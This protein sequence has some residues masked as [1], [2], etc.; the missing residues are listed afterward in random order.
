MTV[1]NKKKM[2]PDHATR[3]FKFVLPFQFN[4][5]GHCYFYKMYALKGKDMPSNS[6]TKTCYL[7][8]HGLDLKIDIRYPNKF[9]MFWNFSDD[10]QSFLFRFKQHHITLWFVMCMF[11]WK[12]TIV[13]ITFHEK[14]SFVFTYTHTNVFRLF[15]RRLDPLFSF[16]LSTQNNQ[17]REKIWKIEWRIKWQRN[18][19]SVSC[20]F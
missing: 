16:H 3:D 18:L 4:N 13:P 8:A 6:E 7:D 14:V 20:T 15:D 9:P 19:C 12:G 11:I 10:V 1:V 2:Y 5:T 17:T